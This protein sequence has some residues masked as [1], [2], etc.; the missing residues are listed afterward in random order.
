M[1]YSFIPDTFNYNLAS[2]KFSNLEAF[3][4]CQINYKMKFEQFIS[5]YI[6]FEQVQNYI[7]SQNVSIPKMC[8]EDYNFYHKY[9]NVG[10]SYIYIRNNYHVENLSEVEIQKLINNDVNDDFFRD[11]FRKVIFEK[12]EKIFFGVPLDENLVK[13][14]SIIFEFAYNQLKCETVE[15][16]NNI[17]KIINESFR[18]LEKSLFEHLNLQ[19]SLIIY[20]GIPDIFYKNDELKLKV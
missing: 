9:S 13:S 7:N 15:Q 1:N 19:S 20:N 17:V 5:R 16:F 8:D 18:I 14:Q 10:S 2:T 4:Q 6:N 11:T 12:G 3:I